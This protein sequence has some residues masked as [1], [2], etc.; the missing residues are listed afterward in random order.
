MT[1][2]MV[3]EGVFE[4]TSNS[5]PS[6]KGRPR[7]GRREGHHG[8]KERLVTAPK[9]WAAAAPRAQEGGGRCGPEE[10]K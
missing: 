4:K 2:W 3:G 10:R 5:D 8:W 6:G 9:A 7:E 1:G